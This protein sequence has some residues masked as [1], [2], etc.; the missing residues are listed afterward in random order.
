V[1]T[2]QNQREPAPTLA[3]WFSGLRDGW[4]QFWFTPADRLALHVVRFLSGLL[5]FVWLLPLG[6]D[7]QNLLSW[8]GWFDLKALR[9]LARLPGGNGQVASW[10]LLYLFGSDPNL[11][12]TLY[13]TALGVFALFALGI[14]TRLTAPLTWVMVVSFTSNP[15]IEAD[16]D[17]VLNLLAFYLMVG[18]LLDSLFVPGQTW[19]VRLLGR[20]PLGIFTPRPAAPVATESVSANVALRLLQ[21]HLAIVLVTSGVHKLQ[22]GDWWGGM[23][24]WPLMFPPFEVTVSELRSYANTIEAYLALMNV[25]AYATLAWQIGFPLFAW[26][27][28]ARLVLIGGAVAGWLGL[29]FL[30]RI[31]TFGPLLLIGCLSYLTSAEWRALLAWLPRLRV[32]AAIPEEPPAPPAL[33]A[34]GAKRG[35]GVTLS[36]GR[37]H[38]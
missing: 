26:K 1:K 11:L 9:E 28:A 3:G 32:P 38:G 36:S 10:S 35:E 4:I 31:P 14:A 34:A 20:Q 15:A 8:N 27:P 18:Y 12:L 2:V 23:A 24:H 13:L 22:V 7:L 5:F 33:V 25:A 19:L 37:S 30:Y 29:I 6:S 17:S 16:A 21:V